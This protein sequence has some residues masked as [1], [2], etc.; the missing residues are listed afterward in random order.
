MQSFS[1]HIYCHSNNGS[2]TGCSG[3]NND[4]SNITY[5]C[6]IYGINGKDNDGN[7]I[8]QLLIVVALVI[9]V[10]MAISLNVVVSNIKIVT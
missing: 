9:K 10:M 8:I 4:I 6:S 7:S 3:N 1:T 5:K 2:N